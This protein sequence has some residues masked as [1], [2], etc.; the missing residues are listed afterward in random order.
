MNFISF[1]FWNTLATASEDYIIERDCYFDKIGLPVDAKEHYTKLKSSLDFDAEQNGI[2]TLPL[3]AARR[4][5]E[6]YSIFKN[7]YEVYQD[8]QQMALDN[9][10]T[11]VPKELLEE[12]AKDA[13]LFICSNTNFISGAVIRHWLR[14]YPFTKM[15]FSDELGI[16]KPNPDIFNGIVYES[17]KILPG[18]ATNRIIHI[19]DRPCD[20]ECTQVGMASKIVKSPKATKSW[21][22]KM[23]QDKI[24]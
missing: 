15:L 11:I 21:I 13:T 14:D 3:I 5:I 7:S 22:K 12:L 23:I 10:P 2:T 20:K 9:P 4:L 17:R 24:V 19:G 8:F 1:D 16:S 18:I 6:P